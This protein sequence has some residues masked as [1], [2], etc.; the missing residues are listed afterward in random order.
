VKTL[1]S[2]AISVLSSGVE[3]EG[4]MLRFTC[5]QLDRKLY[6]E[7]NAALEAIGG[8][9]KKGPK[10]HLF[11]ASP[12]DAL[13]QILVDGGFHDTK[14]ELN[15]FFTPEP[16]AKKIVSRA[17][18]KGKIVLEP[19]AGRGAIADEAIAQGAKQVYCIEIDGKHCER[20]VGRH[21]NML[22]DRADFLL[23]KS[24]GL[25]IERVVM[26]SPFARQADIAHVTRAF[27]FLEPKGL[28]VA[29]LS[30]GI[31]FRDNAKSKAFR[32]LVASVGGT[33]EDLPDE[34]FKESGTN[35]NTVLVTMRK[36]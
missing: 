28:L 36:L 8:K 31:K 4:N 33:I 5:G 12:E 23:T 9:W 21:K 2:E 14:Q 3:I 20:L 7:V 6:V 13:D 34:S 18:V 24:N 22:V 30:A 32:A 27:E 19:S 15:Q 29:I 11:E 1:S 16:L 35:V 10:A 25:K 17:D 26:N